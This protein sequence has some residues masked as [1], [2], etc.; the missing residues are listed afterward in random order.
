M[1]KTAV[2]LAG[3]EGKRLRPYTEELPKALIK[4]AGRELL[5]RIMKQLQEEGVE[6]FVI[7]INERFKE[8]IEKFLRENNFKAEVVPNPNPEKENGYSL[9]LAKDRVKGRFAVVMSDHVYEK[10]FIKEAIKGEGLIVDRMGLY[11]DRNEATKVKCEEGKIKEIGKEIKDYDGF[12]TGFFV[13]NDEIFKKAEE[14]LK[15]TDKLTMSQLAKYAELPCTEVSGY[16]W[17]DIDTPEDIEKARKLIVKTAIKGAGDGFISRNLNRKISTRI[18]PYLVERFTPNQVT[19]YTFLLGLFSAFV[20][21]FSPALG[22]ILLQ[23]SSVLDGLDGEIARA[24]MQTTKFGAWLD[25]LLDRYVDFAFLTALTFHMKPSWEFMP[26]VFLALFG[27]LM[28]SYS[29]E[30]YKGAYCEDA[31]VVIKELRYLLG[32]R[33]ERIF[34][35]MIFTLFGWLKALLVLLALITNIRVLLTIYLVWKKKGNV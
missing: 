29:T 30:R 25:S 14:L 17:M 19:I 33:D 20:A 32:K 21:Y 8:K 1:I 31:Y 10:E 13:L 23:I 11:I 24:R 16:F 7:V 18:S 3:G 12:D 5:Y 34:L 2:I 28:V 15:E 22:G 4:V 27:T 26:W 35:I 6:K 9:Y